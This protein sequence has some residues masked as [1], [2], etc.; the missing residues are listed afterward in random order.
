MLPK[1]KK[2]VCSSQHARIR[3]DGGRRFRCS[4]SKLTI[5]SFRGRIVGETEE[6]STKYDRNMEI[7]EEENLHLILQP[8]RADTCI[9]SKKFGTYVKEF[10]IRRN[11]VIGQ[12]L[13]YTLEINRNGKWIEE[14][15]YDSAINAFKAY[16]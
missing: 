10:Q 6:F 11:N 16:K 9:R 12:D 15:S 4:Y 3:V 7:V 13:K 2:Y 8:A 5:F 14:E 1:L